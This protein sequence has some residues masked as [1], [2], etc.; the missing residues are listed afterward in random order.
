M[1]LFKEFTP[2]GK[3]D[4]AEL[5]RYVAALH[6]RSIR[7]A[8]KPL[9][10]D[11]EEIGPGYCYGPAFGHWDIVHQIMDVIEDEP[12]HARKQLLNNLYNMTGDGFLP[13]SIW[14]SED[15]PDGYRWNPSVTHPP[16]WPVVVDE[17]ISRQFDQALL[18]D[19]YEALVRQIGWWE[20]HRKAEGGGY[21]YTDISEKTW[22][23]G[24]DEGIR[25]D[26]V[27]TGKWACI[28]ATCHVYLMIEH[29]E[30]WAGLLNQH[31]NPFA[32]KAQELADF[33]RTTLWSDETG[34]FH[35]LWA[36]RDPAFRCYAQE[37]VW[38]LVV[39]I[40]TP[41][42]VERM[43]SENLLN[44]DRF[45]TKHPL[46]TVARND[47]RFEQR[48]WRGPAWNSITW[49]TARGCRRYGQHEAAET[50]LE[51]ALDASAEQFK[52]TGVIWEYYHSELGD[53]EQV[54]RKPQTP[55]NTPCKDYLGHNPLIAMARMWQ[56]CV[57]HRIHGHE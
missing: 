21:Y 4:W 7:P 54:A 25:F 23:S 48:M 32:A 40:A 14:L 19:C 53:Q 57:S 38:P 6:T 45:F 33:V 52:R 26:E 11:W 37:G 20:R 22:E 39:G 46:S 31:A 12:E 41:S 2:P 3:P 27:P 35:D 8:Q 24:V 5:L 34:F 51:A 30:R 49:W 1:T 36:Q 50:L 43:I 18:E 10:Y 56:Q 9:P 28:D 55:F 47:P 15:D 16:V 17:I 13:G 42:Q 44:P 29:A